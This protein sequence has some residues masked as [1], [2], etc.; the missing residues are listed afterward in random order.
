M[1]LKFDGKA[2]NSSSDL[3]RIVAAIKPGSKV[4]VELWRKGEA[5]KVTVEVGEL[6]ED[7]MLARASKKKQDDDVGETVSR[8]GISV[9]ELS[10]G[11]AARIANQW[12]FAGRGCQRIGCA[13]RRAASGRCAVG[14]RQCANSLACAI[15]RIHQACAQGAEC[16]VAGAAR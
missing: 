12:W 1:I 2:V 9:S 8:L 15:Q 3:P 7:G 10:K 16:R 14:D 13:F 5:K 4:V 11:A 6:P